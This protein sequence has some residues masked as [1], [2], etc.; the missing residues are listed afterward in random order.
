MGGLQTVQKGSCSR[1]LQ[2]CPHVWGNNMVLCEDGSC[3]ESIQQV[4]HKEQCGL[5]QLLKGGFCFLL[6]EHGNVVSDLSTK[7]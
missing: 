5:T 6:S 2:S 4:L 3:A 1:D 7:L